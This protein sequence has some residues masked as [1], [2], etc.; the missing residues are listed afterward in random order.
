MPR[1]QYAE[2]LALTHNLRAHTDQFLALSARGPDRLNSLYFWTRTDPPTYYNGNDSWF[3]SCTNRR[4]TS[5]VLSV[6]IHSA[7]HGQQYLLLSTTSGVLSGETLAAR[8]RIEA[9]GSPRRV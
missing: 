2:Y 7:G 4:Q 3:G 6:R 1:D 5:G 8:D 9:G